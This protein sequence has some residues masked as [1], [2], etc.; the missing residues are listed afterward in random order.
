MKNQKYP[1]GNDCGVTLSADGKFVSFPNTDM[2]EICMRLDAMLLRAKV[3][4]WGVNRKDME[5]ENEIEHTI[6]VIGNPL[7]EIQVNADVYAEIHT[8]MMGE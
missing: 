3:T 1:N 8:L 7:W 6:L 2:S 4:K 5:M